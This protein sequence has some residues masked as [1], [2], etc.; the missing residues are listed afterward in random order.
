MFEQ[1]DRWLEELREYTGRKESVTCTSGHMPLTA[2]AQEIAIACA[3]PR[4]H[5]GQQVGDWQSRAS[6]L[7]DTLDWIGPELHALVA[8]PS[9]AIHQAITND[10]LVPRQSGQ[11]RLDDTK[12]PLVGTATTA[13]TAI[14]GGDDLLVAAWRDLVAACRN[15]D[16]TTYPHERI[17]LLRDTLIDMSEYRKQARG[18]GSPVSTAVDVLLGNAS[19]VRYAR[20]MVGDPVDTTTPFDPRAEVDLT[21]EELADLAERCIVE[22]PLAGEYVV[23]FRL[24]PAF[25][26]SVSCVTHG[27]VTFYDAQMLASAL[28]DHQRARHLDVVPEEL[29]TDEVRELQLSAKVDDCTGFE[30]DPQMVYA[31]VTVRDVERHRAVETARM[32]LDTVLAVVGI[33]DGMWKVLGGA[34]FFDGEPWYLPPARWGLKE[35]LPESVFYQNDFFTTRLSEMNVDGHEITAEAAQQLQ[36]VLRLQAALTNAPRSDSEAIVMAA[37]RAIEHCNTWTA[38]LGGR[39]WYKFADEYLSDGYAVT[40]LAN[41]VVNDVFAAVEQDLPDSTPGAVTPP[42]L[43]ATRQDITV[44]GGWGTRIDSQKTISH[45]TAL[46][47]IYADHWLAR[48]LAETDDILSSGGALRAAI[49]LEKHRLGVRVQRLRRTRNAAIHGGTLSEVA[50]ATISQFARISRGRH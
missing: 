48:R 46:R 19:S 8:S 35:P 45:V 36:P 47:G 7:A 12:R 25:V 32:Y 39:N 37:V 49:T 26:P 42:E 1:R 17:A 31:R 2:I 21:E 27:D 28:T 41:R 50:C 11:S 5:N 9:Q 18:H 40:A 22:L 24:H 6:D 10:L 34:L 15:V 4:P 43:E 20:A 3:D 33:P 38:P 16:H 44:P 30:Y 23:W 14:L 13:L 29:L